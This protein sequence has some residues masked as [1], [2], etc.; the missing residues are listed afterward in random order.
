VRAPVLAVYGERSFALP[1]GR[2]LARTVPGCRLVVVP[3]AGH[4]HP[5]AA[6]EGFLAPV[7]AFLTEVNGCPR[8]TRA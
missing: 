3:R 2:L 1:S 6:P 7:R 5:A 4:F 8:P